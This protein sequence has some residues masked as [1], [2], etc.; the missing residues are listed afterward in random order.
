MPGIVTVI[1]VPEALGSESRPM[2]SEDTLAR[3]GAWLNQHRL[4]TTEL[5]VAAPRYRKVEVL[6]TVV[7]KDTASSGDVQQKL[8][9]M[10]SEYFH[11]LHGGAAGTGWEF[12]EPISFA[13]STGVSSTPTASGAS[14]G[15]A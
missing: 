4:V 6:A 8:E 14:T 10:L 13:E 1:V 2:P 7:V 3:V 12:G 5:F 15:R 9:R 11:P